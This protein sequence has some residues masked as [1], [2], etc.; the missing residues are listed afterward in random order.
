MSTTIS[1]ITGL[2]VGNF[3]TG[4]PAATP[5]AVP[6]P[7]VLADADARAVAQAVLDEQST[8]VRFTLQD[9]KQVTFDVAAVSAR[10]ARLVRQETGKPWMWWLQAIEDDGEDLDTLAVMIYVGMLEQGET[11][12]DFEQLETELSYSS[13]VQGDVLTVGDV[14]AESRAST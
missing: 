4:K 11:D 7:P 10:S 6:R 1:E 13:G 5:T 14:R 9:G 12:V 3:D 2:P 8:T